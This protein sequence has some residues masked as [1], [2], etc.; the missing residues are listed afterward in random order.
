MSNKLYSINTHVHAVMRKI[1]LHAYR[2]ARA[3]L[4]VADEIRC[5]PAYFDNPVFNK[6]RAW[7]AQLVRSLP[8]NHKV[9]GSIL[10]SAKN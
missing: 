2:V 1:E 8:S 6:G 10:G 7:L 3:H 5:L 4:R 9:P